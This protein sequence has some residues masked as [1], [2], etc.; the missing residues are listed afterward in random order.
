MNIK[1]AA[2]TAAAL[3]LAATASWTTI[4][5]A[6]ADSRPS[7]AAKPASSAAEEPADKL[8]GKTLRSLSTYGTK[9][10][11]IDAASQ[12]AM[13]SRSTVVSHAAAEKSAAGAFKF[14][15]GH[16]PAEVVLTKLTVPTYGKETSED[17]TKTSK[18]E[19]EIADR[20]VWFVVFHDIDQPRW[21]PIID[22]SL[23]HIS[24]P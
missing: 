21:A 17:P 23:I 8:S 15:A 3:V 7:S 11:V 10:T 12:D 6:T 18:I 5:A 19:P 4:Q 14:T 22:L 2:G 16:V 1:I 13:L 24:E 20:L 9:L